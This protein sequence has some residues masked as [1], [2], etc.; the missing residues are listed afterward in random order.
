[1]ANL[2]EI[3]FFDAPLRI[4]FSDETSILI[5]V[6]A[7]F[8]AAGLCV[9][10]GWASRPI[11]PQV[12]SGTQKL[13]PIIQQTH[14]RHDVNNTLG[15]EDNLERA[16]ALAVELPQEPDALFLVCD[17]PS[18]RLPLD[19]EKNC[20][21]M[22]PAAEGVLGKDVYEA[23]R[24]IIAANDA[25]TFANHA[26]IDRAFRLF[27]TR[28]EPLVVLYGWVDIPAGKRLCVNQHGRK[29][30]LQ[31][32]FWMRA[33]LENGKGPSANPGQEGYGFIA[34][35]TSKSPAQSFELGYEHEGEWIPLAEASIRDMPSFDAFIR[36]IF[37]LPIPWSELSECYERI[38]LEP[39]SRIQRKHCQIL[40]A[41]PVHTRQLGKQPAKPDISVIIPLYGNLRYLQDQLMCFSEDRAFGDFAE[42]IFVLDDCSLIDAFASR[43]DELYALYGVPFRWIYNGSNQGF[44]G[45]NNLGASIAKGKHLVFANSDIFPEKPGWLD[46]FRKHLNDN[47]ATGLAGCRLLSPSGTIQ[48]A[49]MKFRYKPCLKIWTNIHPGA[50]CEIEPFMSDSI[51]AVTGA[52]IALR[53]SLFEEL[54]G[55]SQDYLI[56]D[57]EDSD[58]CFKVRKA[59]K[60]IAYLRDIS[61]VHLERQ[62]VALWGANAIRQR[63]TIFNAVIHQNKWKKELAAYATYEDEI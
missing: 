54:G 15:L 24:Q 55:W 31:S 16:F 47:P 1:M 23:I 2:Q 29:T 44:S 46:A 39:L 41:R 13:D 42:L 61:L 37:S 5:K 48:H 34:S 56:G 51:D 28:Y 8:C 17:E 50:G 12:M 7:L 40:A 33:D 9:V 49:G 43:A 52:C 21:A 36:E 11:L 45:A 10:G 30:S 14:Y 27:S 32:Y 20:G 58:L 38:L 53:K 19:L 6:D 63:L 57:F 18:F 59:H 22:E 26:Q 60:R 25:L 3:N 62:S 35:F 4:L